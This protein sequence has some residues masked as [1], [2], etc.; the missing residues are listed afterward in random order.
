VRAA[1]GHETAVQELLARTANPEAPNEVN[2]SQPSD[3]TP[4]FDA[5][6][7]EEGRRGCVVDR[8]TL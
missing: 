4:R 6:N 8:P 7:D 3:A 5:G 1:I 2:V